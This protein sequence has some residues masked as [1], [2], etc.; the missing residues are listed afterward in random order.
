[1]SG[2][3][4]IIGAGMG[5]LASAAMLAARGYDVTVVEK[6][7]WVG[8]K[9]RTVPVDGKAIEAGPTVFTMRD[10]F[11]QVFQTCGARLDDFVNVRRAEVIA[12]HAWDDQEHLDLFADPVRSEEAVGDFAGA[13]AAKGY[14]AFREDTRKMFDM[15]DKPMLR[16]DN[17][18]SPLPLLW[19]IGLHRFDAFATM[20]PHQSMWKALGTYFA[21]PRLQ[22]LFGRYSTY[23]GSSPFLAPA[24]LM[25]IAHV[26]AKGVWLIDGG[27]SALAEG[28]RKLAESK[29]VKFRTG[30]AV[31]Q[32]LAD[33]SGATGIRLAN[34]DQ[35][36][37]D[38]VI[39]NADPSALAE[40]KLGEQGARSVK[41][42]DPK[43]RS[44]SALVWF[45]H[46][47][48]SG[49]DL[50]HHN[51]FFSPDYRREFDEI[52]GGR[53]PSDPSVYLCAQDR[54]ASAAHATS[55]AEGQRERIQ[56]IVNAPANGDTYSY[57]TEE[58]DQ[59]TRAMR[60]TL[61]RC[62]LTLEEEM[63]HQL[64][65]PQ[66][67]EGLFPAT[68]GA[69]YGR[70]SHG[71]AASFLR[72]G[73]RTRIPRLYCAGGSTHPSAGVPMAALSGLLAVRTIEKDLASTKRFLPVATP[74]G[75]S[76]RSARTGSTG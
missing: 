6:E 63:P 27:I 12:R 5:G 49:F 31:A 33:K 34:G 30:V 47:K 72:Q 53:S 42:L 65:T 51:V 28:L 14:R 9:A 50:Q 22:Q 70:A 76:M 74:G 48:S 52:A 67:W 66:E 59:C 2:T 61:E 11:D 68:G 57:S 17:V 73:P 46:A 16:G 4:A 21:D 13:D 55:I 75:I 60:N 3:I 64:A 15:L 54:S 8:G 56:I 43:K 18:S 45:A 19:R 7:H 32:V 69:L 29:G 62:G 23:C 35:I 10:V 1:M 36:S 41:R 39:C 44:F 25:L 38:A 37:A 24:T 71:S 26:E 20:R 58:R 40:G